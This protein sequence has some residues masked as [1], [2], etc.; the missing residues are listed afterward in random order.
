MK[1]TNEDNSTNNNGTYLWNKFDTDVADSPP[2]LENSDILDLQRN[3]V[4]TTRL[5]IIFFLYLT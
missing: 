2:I 5:D 1:I 3:R 4:S